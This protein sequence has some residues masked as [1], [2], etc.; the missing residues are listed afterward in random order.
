MQIPKIDVQNQNLPTLLSDIAAG[1]LQIPRF[2]RDFVW[3]V[4]K[5]RAL[6]D[7]MYKEF[8]IG[9]FFLWKAPSSSP[10]I[11]RPLVELGVPQPSE[12]EQITYIL[13]GQQRLTSLYV[14]I[15]GIKVGSTDYGRI[16]IDLQN[17]LEYDRSEDEGYAEDIFVYRTPNNTRY[18]ALKDLFGDR[19]L[20]IYHGVSD[21]R[22]GYFER[23][24]NLFQT[25]PFSVVSIKEQ[26][27]GNAID[28]F[29]RINQA[30]K[31]LSRYDLV[32]ANVWTDDF[33]FRKR[34]E[35]V[36]RRFDELGFGRIDETIF[37]QLFA[38]V[39]QDKCTTVAELTLDSASIQKVWKGAVR[40]LEVAIEFV[41]TNMGVARSEY[42][43][44]R[45]LLAV[46]GYYF[47]HR[48]SPAL[49]AGERQVLWSWFW[50]VALSERYSSTSP[51]RM[52]DDAKLLLPAINGE[53]VEFAYQTKVTPDAVLR[54][55]M[56]STSSALRNAAICMM[57]LKRPLNLKD[58]SEVNLK[59]DFF[60]NLKQAERHHIFPVGFL[61]TKQISTSRVHLLPNFCFIP[62]DL[63]KQIG[64][65]APSEY[66]AEL[67]ES[68]PAFASAA[69]THILRSES[70]A[71][72]SDSYSEFLQERAEDVA[73][74][75]NGLLEGIPVVHAE[76]E[77]PAVQIDILEMRV[78]GF[79]DHRLRAVGGP[80]YWRES[81]PGDV[82]T[83]VKDRI[84][85]HIDRH[86]YEEEAGFSDGRRRL[87]FCDV[88]DYEKIILKNWQHF[89]GFFQRKDEFQRHM[90]TYRALRNC[91]QHN[92]PPTEVE[93]KSG[94]AA[95]LW[96]GQVIDRYDREIAN[97]QLELEEEEVVSS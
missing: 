52:A 26:T 70:V 62:A 59:S 16:C 51:T 82:I 72:Q 40:S 77:V 7:S 55:K 65:R 14:A 88:A 32:C 31:P 49:S 63:N 95:I 76:V 35:E 8:P 96:I 86:P 20:Q 6:L 83:K 17:A 38:L 64:S 85:D 73:R 39:L 91:S 19:M 50:R 13:D 68:N 10:S 81:V 54:T 92:R 4:T 79:V 15:K 66:L 28:I 67:R 75:L 42:L 30:G 97:H 12:G 29:Q 43:P 47:Y 34:V 5:T 78:R 56:T 27:L 58:G 37:T 46:L 84:R 36:N 71:L 89:A 74:E 61:R 69:K 53:R 48:G 87:E 22:K 33:D 60:S 24:R 45:G 94:D 23:A 3:P 9:T 21:E 57:A 11:A 80:Y 41:R 1:K 44:Y 18:V 93:K 2:Q 25:Y 90:A